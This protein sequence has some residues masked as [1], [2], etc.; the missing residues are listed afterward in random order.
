M[1]GIQSKEYHALR[2]GRMDFRYR[3][4]R[5]TAAVGEAITTHVGSPS[6][7][8][9]LEVGTADGLLLSSLNRRFRFTTAVGIDLSPELM[10]ENRDRSISLVLGDAERIPFPTRS[11]DI[12]IA[13]VVVEHLENQDL[14]IRECHRVLVKGGVAVFITPNPFHDALARRIGYVEPGLH[15]HSPSLKE[16]SDLLEKQDFKIVETRRF[17]LCPFFKMPFETD[18]E[19]LLCALGLSWM[20]SN[21]IIVCKRL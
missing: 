9:C 5:R 11:F 10:D 13:A 1:S 2:V 7:S 21:Q 20:M 19:R 18:I 6:A 15:L 14:M 12:I 3:L 8:R 17:M 16:L 4:E